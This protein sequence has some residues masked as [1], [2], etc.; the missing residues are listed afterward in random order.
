MPT[1]QLFVTCLVDTFYPE[2]GEAIVDVLSRLGVTV[3]FAPDQTCCGQPAFNAG[4]RA[5]AR[6]MAEH[7]IEVFER[8]VRSLETS[9]VCDIVSPSGSCVHMMR[10]NYPELFADD[11]AWLARTQS[12]AARTFEFSEY[13]VDK[14]GV[15]DIGARWD[16]TLT[17][18]PSCHLARGLGIDRQPRALLAAVKGAQIVELPHADECCGFGG[19]FS[20]THPEVSKEMLVK[21]IENLEASQSPT[22]VVPDAGCL[23]HIAGGLHRMGKGQRAVHLAEVLAGKMGESRE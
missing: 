22:L 9:Q 18:H 4:L 3:D 2:V 21:K 16:G 6:Q 15:T 11:P 12:L 14:L 20:V 8:P 13:I 23:M 17:Y 19:I 5:D 1:V 7:M 10:V